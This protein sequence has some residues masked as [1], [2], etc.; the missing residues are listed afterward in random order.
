MNESQRNTRFTNFAPFALILVSFFWGATFPWVKKAL[1]SFSPLY[2]V[3]FRFLLAAFLFG[4]IYLKSPDKKKGILQGCILG[5]ALGSAF[6]FQTL[7]IK[8]SSAATMGL[9]TGLILPFMFIMET[10]VARKKLELKVKIC[11]FLAFAGFLLLSWEGGMRFRTADLLGVAAAVGFTLQIFLTG[12]YAPKFG[13]MNLNFYQMLAISVMA[14]MLAP[15]FEDIASLDFSNSVAVSSIIFTAVFCSFFAFFVQTW[16]QRY[17][18]PS[19]TTLFL[20]LEPLFAAIVSWAVYYTEITLAKILG[21]V[22][23]LASVAVVQ[24]KGRVKSDE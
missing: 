21:A 18:S 16:G 22:F 13:I 17:V 3:A 1:E 4:I 8:Y 9:L 11:L 15:F 6:C 5:L 24:M 12:R 19:M 2:W 20:G 14:F 7:G 10:F 23:M